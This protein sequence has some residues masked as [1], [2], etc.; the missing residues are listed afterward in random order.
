MKIKTLVALLIFCL[1]SNLDIAQSKIK[2]IKAGKI[3]DVE[4]GKVLLNQMILI[5]GNIIKNI[6]EKIAIPDSSEVLDL[7]KYTVLPG[8]IDCHTH[9]TSEPSGDYYGDLFRMTA[10]DYAVRAPIYTKRTLQ[11][12]F[13]TCRDLGSQNLIDIALRNAI[14]DGSIEGPRMYVATFALGATGGHSD[15]T[16]RKSVV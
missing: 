12:G 6:A 13:T 5:E 3:I 15:L 4:N 2:I 9:L 7:S 8:L 16:D 14:N 1:Y 11:A 10:V